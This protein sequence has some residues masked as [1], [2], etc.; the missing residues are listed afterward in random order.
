MKGNPMS[1]SQ[2]FEVQLN[3]DTKVILM[4]PGQDL[5]FRN[6]SK[7]EKMIR[8]IFGPVN[9]EKVSWVE[10][11]EKFEN[12]GLTK[13]EYVNSVVKPILIHCIRDS[14]NYRKHL[15][16]DDDQRPTDSQEYYADFNPDLDLKILKD[17][18]L[19]DGDENEKNSTPQLTLFFIILRKSGWLGLQEKAEETE[20]AESFPELG[21]D[22]GEVDNAGVVSPESVPPEAE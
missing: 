1:F 10:D 11:S 22:N 16:V 6:I 20:E 4:K 12:T 19:F 5:Y 21:G 14:T 15:I 2:K 8:Y 9:N 7:I 17:Q 18:G 13:Y 3:K